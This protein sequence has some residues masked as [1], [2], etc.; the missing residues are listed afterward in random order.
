MRYEN[1]EK[2]CFIDR[3]NRFTANIALSGGIEACHVK[4]T[5]RLNELLVPGADVMVQRCEHK[6]RRTRY[7]LIAVYKG[8]RLVN[9]DSQAP[10]RVFCEWL[11]GGGLF[12]NL[13]LLSPERKFGSSRLDFYIEADGRR[14]FAEIKGVTLETD[15]VALFPDA[16]TERGLRHINELIKCV[17]AGFD[18]YAVFVVQMKGVRYFAPNL[19][20]QP[21]FGK[22]LG[23]A[24]AAGVRL[25]ALDCG[26]DES[27]IEINDFV[28]VRL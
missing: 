5:G 8:T 21:G 19:H 6:A 28:D 26:V 20:A 14:I 2:A 22:A 27:G 4:T 11:R 1:T 16:P 23:Q 15:G 12:E 9:V 13:T 18:A 10:N 7:D 24:L 17:K 25:I 3:P